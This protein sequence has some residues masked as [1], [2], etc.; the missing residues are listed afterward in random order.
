MKKPKTNQEKLKEDHFRRVRALFRLSGFRRIPQLTDKEFTFRGSTCDI[1]DVFFQEN[2]IVFVEYT[3][4]SDDIPTHLKKKSVPFRKIVDHRSEFLAYLLNTFAAFGPAMADEQYDFDNY[5]VSILYASRFPVDS[6]TKAEVPEVGYLDYNIVRYL[7]SAARTMRLS[8]RY[9]ILEFLGVSADQYGPAAIKPNVGAT[10]FYEGSVLPEAHSNF[11]P[12]YKV[13]SF[14]IDPETLL[15]RAY[16][17]RR[18][19]WRA[20]ASLYQRM[21]S[22]KK[23]E[24][25]RSYLKAKK[26]VFVNNIIATL[27]PETAIVTSE[28]IPIDSVN[29]KK[30]TRARIQLPDRFNSVGIID[31]QHR[32]YA[33]HEGG[34]FEAEISKLRHR[35]NLLVTGIIFP[36]GQSEE[37]R[38]RFEAEIF[39]E[40]NS[41]QTAAK[42]DLKQEIEVLLRPYSGISIAKRVMNRINDAGPLSN[43]FERYFFDQ[44]KLKTTSIV[45]YALSHL[46][47]VGGPDSLFAAWDHPMKGDLVN[48]SN[49]ALLDDYVVHCALEINRFLSAVKSNITAFR[50]T[51][52][53]KVQGFFL[54]TTTVNGC[55]SCFRRVVRNGKLQTFDEY[56]LLL[57]DIEKLTFSDYKSSQYNA[58]GEKIYESFF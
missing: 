30:T 24:S 11:G 49:D 38:H 25:V 43:L 6:I 36:P 57:T 46:V 55:L 16:V 51:P 42:S 8:A 26:R 53:R 33:Y 5:H 21:I 41:T 34:R 28:N 39:L 23:I 10:S 14:Y 18:D 17:L 44:D 27:P 29:I 1:D 32:L 58:L 54:T 19:G 3:V 35:Q 45:S 13:V 22:A 37:A 56:K 9:E 47:R 48:H 2:V 12:G 40:I 50:W 4:K 52:D 7:E 15:R 20:G 31:G